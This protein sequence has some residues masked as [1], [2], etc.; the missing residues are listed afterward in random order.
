MPEKTDKT[1]ASVK[2]ALRISHDKLDA[3]LLELIAAARAEMIRAG[4]SSSRADSR[5]DALV[6]DAIKVFCLARTTTDAAKLDRY[7]ESWRLQIDNLRKSEGYWR[8]AE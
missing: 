6:R 5:R 2:T 7:A 1:L 3:E 4:V 8:S